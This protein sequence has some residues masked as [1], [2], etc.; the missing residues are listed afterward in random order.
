M[1]M[2]IITKPPKYDGWAP[3]SVCSEVR[4]SKMDEGRLTIS[5]ESRNLGMS[6]KA[7]NENYINALRIL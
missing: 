1:M 7:R 3:H 5:L 4:G 2:I 6:H